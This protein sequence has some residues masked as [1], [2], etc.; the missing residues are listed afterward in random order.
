MT[1]S[2]EAASISILGL[3]PEDTSLGEENS[4]A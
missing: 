3:E 1:Q 4:C 2:K